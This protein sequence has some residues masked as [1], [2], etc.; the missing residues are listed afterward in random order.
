M[1]RPNTSSRGSGDSEPE[2]EPPLLSPLPPGAVAS[3][4]TGGSPSPER[5]PL[6]LLADL[7]EKEAIISV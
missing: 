6:R 7:Q 2:L 3:P 1:G 5:V 4:V